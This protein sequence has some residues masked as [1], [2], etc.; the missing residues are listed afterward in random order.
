MLVGGGF[1]GGDGDG[2]PFT[3]GVLGDRCCDQKSLI[4]FWD[5]HGGGMIALVWLSSRSL[6][7]EAVNV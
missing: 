6:V 3:G 1:G 4:R 5:V 2:I 7:R